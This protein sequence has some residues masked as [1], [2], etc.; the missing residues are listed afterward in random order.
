M[1]TKS[2]LF[3]I[4]V[5]GTLLG[6]TTVL[7]A[8]TVNIEAAVKY[9]ELTDSLKQN[10]PITDKQWDTFINLEGNKTYVHSVFDSASLVGYRRALEMVYM[11]KNNAWLQKNLKANYWYAILIKRYKDKEDSLK[12]YLKETLQSPA[13]K[14]VMYKYVYE[15]LPKKDRHPVKDLKFY[16]NAIGMD[17]VSYPNGIFMSL[18][19]C[20]N[21]VKIKNGILEAHELHHQLRSQMELKP[22]KEEHKGL[23]YAIR[24]IQNEG[25]ADMIDKTPMLASFDSVSIREWLIDPAPAS[26]RSVDSAFSVTAKSN[27][28]IFQ[29]DKPYRKLL[30]SSAGHMPGFYMARIMVRHG[31]EKQM[32]KTAANPFQFIYLYNEAAK[33]DAGH[34]PVFS[35]V[36]IQY[37]KALEKMYKK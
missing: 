34:P 7:K 36:V 20:D 29:N 22:L 3:I 16:Y 26:I 9:W 19:A 37:L 31:Y 1:N 5:I 14:E 27:G 30:R 18:M 25:I 4:T 8:Q 35:E 21:N 15:Y 2:I 17:A 33:K 23:M 24:S 32:I 6:N 13:Y 28:T 12:T 10:K 11:P